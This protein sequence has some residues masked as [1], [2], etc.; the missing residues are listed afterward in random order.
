MGNSM[1]LLTVCLCV[2]ANM[3][4]L[5]SGRCFGKEVWE[6]N[7]S[8]WPFP[9]PSCCARIISMQPVVRMHGSDE[10][11]NGPKLS[12]MGPGLVWPRSQLLHVHAFC[13]KW[14]SA[15]DFCSQVR[16]L[17]KLNTVYQLCGINQLMLTGLYSLLTTQSQVCYLIMWIRCM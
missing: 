7:H 8:C 12:L 11:A 15:A 5:I 9:V 4:S 16:C 17:L 10:A 1:K 14:S 2:Q 6:T 13:V 3:S